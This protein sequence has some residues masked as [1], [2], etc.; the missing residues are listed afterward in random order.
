VLAHAVTSERSVCSPYQQILGQAFELLHPNVREAHLAP[1]VGKG[2]LD[3]LHGTFWLAPLLVGLM[4]LPAAGKEQP[5]KLSVAANDRNVEWN[6][7]IGKSILRTYQHADG[8]RLVERNGP[9]SVSFELDIVDGALHYKQASM[10][11]AGLTIPKGIMPRVAGV[12]GPTKFGWRVEV[13]VTWRGHL[14]CRYGG[15]LK[16]A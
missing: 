13:S 10:K 14:I 11:L 12:V 4:K 15:E 7:S 6:R 1:L 2:Q 16:R 3:V 5:V 9:G 8:C